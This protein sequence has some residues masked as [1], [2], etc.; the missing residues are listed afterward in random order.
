MAIRS[1]FTKLIRQ[2]CCAL[3]VALVVLSQYCAYGVELGS[4]PTKVRTAQTKLVVQTQPPAAAEAPAETPV[5][6]QPPAPSPVAAPAPAV[7]AAVPTATPAATN[8]VT[9]TSPVVVAPATP[10]PATP[11]PIAVQQQPTPSS[12]LVGVGGNSADNSGD[13]SNNND[14]TGPIRVPQLTV[15]NISVSD[16]GTKMLPEDMVAG[17][18][19]AKIAL[20]YG[21]ERPNADTMTMKTWTAPVFCYQNLFF[22][23]VMLE[24]HGHERCWPLQP[25]ISGARFFTSYAMMPY[26]A[27]LH[28]P[29]QDRYSTG[30]YRA[31]TAAPCLRQ[32]VPY[33]K[34]ALR[35]QLLTTGTTVLAFQP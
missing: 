19:P 1:S 25:V 24:R 3:P 17:R 31:G 29:L 13:S 30:H 33:D 7:P 27:V 35:M 16:I 9:I 26:S 20:P 34:T 18:L 12:T 15:P 10:L 6:P 14:D 23:D 22:E 5:T 21:P 8:P 4:S 28:P 11:A 2:Q 32:R